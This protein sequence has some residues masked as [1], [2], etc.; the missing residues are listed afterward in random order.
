MYLGWSRRPGGCQARRIVAA[1]V[2]VLL[3]TSTFPLAAQSAPH[4][5]GHKCFAMRATIIGTR[6]A[7]VLSGTARADVIAGL[8]GDDEIIGMD[9]ADRIC[10]GGGRDV[11]V[12]GS[13]R[14]KVA[15]GAGRDDVHGGA[16]AD[17]LHGSSGG[18]AL[19]GGSDADFFYP[20]GGDDSVRGGDG[21]DVLSYVGSPRR[22]R[23]NLARKKARG[24]GADRISGVAQVEGTTFADVIIGSAASEAIYGYAGK[25][26]LFGKGG[27]DYLS[28]DAGDD[29]IDGGASSDYALYYLS[30]APVVARLIQGTASGEGDD[31]LARIENLFGSPNADTLVG[32]AQENHFIG[33]DGGLDDIQGRGGDD[34]LYASVDASFRAGRGVDTIRFLTGPVVADLT[35]GVASADTASLTLIGVESIIGSNADDQLTGNAAANEF[36][37]AG[38]NDVLMGL[39]GEDSLRGD[40]GDDHLDGGLDSD[41]LDGGQGT[42]RCLDGERNRHCEADASPKARTDFRRDTSLGR[43]SVLLRGAAPPMLALLDRLL[44]TNS[45]SASHARTPSRSRGSSDARS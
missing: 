22:I 27:R 25:D 45:E 31:D 26:R 36:D 40:D 18:D 14:D 6:H 41:D 23:A 20:G 7:D 15:A 24:W 8:G 17:D 11:I 12:A 30:P 21:P 5:S 32:D 28:G 33:G 16:G 1:T 38:G 9:G 29:I 2:G 35:T 37:G 39:S 10:A 43:P 42:D 44:E 4:T 3:T 13:D 34:L 19:Y